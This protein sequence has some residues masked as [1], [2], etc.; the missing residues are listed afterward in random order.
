MIESADVIEEAMH[1]DS[2]LRHA[3][4]WFREEPYQLKYQREK[5]DKVRK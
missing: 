5:K 3:R 4:D 1:V 2:K